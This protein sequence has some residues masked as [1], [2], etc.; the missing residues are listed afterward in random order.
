MSGGFT[1]IVVS[2][3]ARLHHDVVGQSERRRADRGEIGGRSP[4]ERPVAPGPPQST[5]SP[6]KTV[7]RSDLQAGAPR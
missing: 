4:E 7:P 6:V 3:L 1:S 5:V 2:R